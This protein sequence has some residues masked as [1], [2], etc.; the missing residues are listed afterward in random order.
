MMRLAAVLDWGGSGP[1]VERSGILEAGN[2]G[3]PAEET[4]P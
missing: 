3:Y 2:P 1:L 4:G